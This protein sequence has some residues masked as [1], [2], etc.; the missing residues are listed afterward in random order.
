MLSARPG[1]NDVFQLRWLGLWPRWLK[2]LRWLGWLRWRLLWMG[3]DLLRE[4]WGRGLWRSGWLLAD[5]QELVSKVGILLLVQL[6]PLLE[7]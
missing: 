1:R 2:L 5:T 7:G 3:H 6:L 4:R